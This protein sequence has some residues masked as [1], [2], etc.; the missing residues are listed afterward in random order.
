MSMVSFRMNSPQST[1]YRIWPKGL[2]K[3]M[4]IICSPDFNPAG[5]F[6]MRVLS[7]LGVI[8]VFGKSWLSENQEKQERGHCLEHWWESTACPCCLF[9]KQS[10]CDF[11]PTFYFPTNPCVTFTKQWSTNPGCTV[12]VLCFSGRTYFSRAL[13][14]IK[15]FS[16]N[17][18]VR[19]ADPRTRKNERELGHM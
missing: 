2:M 7:V 15:P 17:G 10:V 11:T 4:S 3:M 9:V 19:A 18:D 6:W 1:G 13:V 16:V 14:T 8:H 5:S 12:S